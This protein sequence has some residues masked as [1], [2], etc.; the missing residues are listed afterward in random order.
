MGT[1]VSR[2]EL[3]LNDVEFIRMPNLPCHS[4]LQRD[5]FTALSPGP[6]SLAY[7]MFTSGSTGRPKG[8]LI[9]HR[10]IVR[11]VRPHGKSPLQEAAIPVAHLTNVAFDVST[12]EIYAPL[13]NGG[14]VVCIDTA[15]VLEAVALGRVFV[16]ERVRAAI[17]TPALLKQILANSP[18]AINAL[19]TLIVAGDRFDPRDAFK[20]LEI[21]PGTVYNGYG[22]TENTVLST[23]YQLRRQEIPDNGVPI[24]R[25]VSN[26]GIYVMDM[27]Q[28][29]VSPGVL[30]ELVVAGDGLARGYIN[31]S[32]DTHRFVT[33]TI[34]GEQTRAYRTGDIGR[35]RPTDGQL[36]FFGRM[37][38][39][40]KI[41]GHRIELPEIEQ[42]LLADDRVADA[43]VVL[44]ESENGEPDLVAFVTLS[45]PDETRDWV[46]LQKL[47]RDRLPAYMCPS[48]FA[49]L[50]TMPV[51]ENGKVDRGSLTKLAQGVKNK[52]PTPMHVA[53]QSD[54]ERALCSEFQSLLGVEVGMTDN[55]FD[56]GGHSL[57]ASKLA[58]RIRKRFDC[59][60]QVLDIMK[61]S[62]PTELRAVLE[63]RLEKSAILAAPWYLQYHTRPD[64]GA[65]LILIHGIWGQGSVFSPMIPRII[66]H[67]NILV[68]H[69]PF[70]GASDGPKTLGERAE[71][72]LD[73][74]EKQ[75]PKDQLV[76][77]GGY[78]L[79]GL[80]AFEMTVLWTKRNRKGPVSLVLLDSARYSSQ[81]ISVE[82]SA[83][84]LE[85]RHA[86]DIFGESQKD[87]IVSHFAKMMPT[88]FMIDAPLTFPGNCLCLVTDESITSGIADWWQTRCPAQRRETIHCTH[89][90]LLDLQM[91][92]QVCE[93]IIKHYKQLARG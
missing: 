67:M 29:I 92:S 11:L 85:I 16:Q 32:D 25:P 18:S 53:P 57:M 28:R 38:Y 15:T 23:I 19:D 34:N 83:S 69:D 43:A 86:I 84:Q 13:L 4:L 2:P 66:D 22:P 68:V 89:H 1:G 14:T 54:T 40:V 45:G 82:D 41:R 59:H 91:V 39:Q 52:L 60:I 63:Q 93:S 36:D 5:K 77:V 9:E 10:G 12:W 21:V 80:I 26:S 72:Y 30:G 17:I 24:G 76:L 48:A 51:S 37:D 74:I 73:D 35:I 6:T 3:V 20:T 49:I 50:Q 46:F 87:V 7:V 47:L 71:L 70:F 55:F 65:T 27:Q 62:T 42:T 81:Q 75:I 8:V 79:G 31:P 61:H 58:L 56:L 88:M 44:R 90:A 64:N 33:V 78:S